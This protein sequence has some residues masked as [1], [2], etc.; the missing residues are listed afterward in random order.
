MKAF[1]AAVEGMTGYKYEV[2]AVLG[3]QPVAGTNYAYLCKGTVVAPDAT[4][5]YLL[6]NVY[7][8]LDGKAE[9]LG[10]KELLPVAAA[11]MTAEWKYNSG[12][13]DPQANPAVTEVFEAALTGKVG[14]VYE[15]LAYI[16]G[17]GEPDECYTL[18]CGNRAVPNA[19]R[20]FCLLTVQKKADGSAEVLDSEAMELGTELPSVP[21][22]QKN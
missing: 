13:S 20:S 21:A 3:S 16:G 7:A 2:L 19:D 17:A 11:K 1:D 15:P 22:E 8:D 5:A 12:D 9:L 18:L 10:T 6:V 14:S 4:P